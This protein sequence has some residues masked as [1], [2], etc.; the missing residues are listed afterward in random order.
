MSVSCCDPAALPQAGGPT[1]PKKLAPPN[2]F[3]LAGRVWTKIPG[4]LHP[5]VIVP[6]G[7]QAATIYVSPGKPG[8]ATS[9]TSLAATS[10]NIPS[11]AY[12]PAPGEWWYYYDSA[13]AIT[14][15]LI[16]TFSDAAAIINAGVKVIG[17]GG[18]ADVRN[19]DADA[20][21]AK[22]LLGI[23]VNARLAGFD[24]NAGDWTR[25][26]GRAFGATQSGGTALVSLLATV[27]PQVRDVPNSDFRQLDGD[28]LSNVIVA[29]RNPPEALWA[30]AIITAY[31]DN[32][33]KINAVNGR[34]DAV[35][36]GAFASTQLNLQ[37]LAKQR[38]AV[39]R[40]VAADLG[41]GVGCTLTIPAVA[42]KRAQICL[43]EI[44]AYCV[45]AIAAPA[46]PAI[47]TSTNLDAYQWVVPLP[48]S[49]VGALLLDYSMQV[50]LPLEG[51]TTNTAT[52]IIC[53][54]HASIA[55]DVKAAYFDAP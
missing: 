9:A 1:G 30:N 26:E 44:K 27:R 40:V 19:A 39:S 25:I 49:A 3:T 37:V 36:N 42:S 32:A 24:S 7:A 29:G 20:D 6:I 16:D 21:F 17:T 15:V 12:L 14:A 33:A 55:W 10:Y 43:L 38:A 8:D 50:A 11:G 54:A 53:P 34:P 52:T 46:A 28:V 45:V 22:A 4:I 41:G 2:F 13:T 5:A 31:D 23:L 48:I 35:G 18:A 51:K 47:V